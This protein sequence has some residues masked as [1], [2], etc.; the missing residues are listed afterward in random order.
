MKP[1][2]PP[3]YFLAAILAMV[4]LHLLFPVR[5]LVDYPWRLAGLL[6]LL[7]GIA[8]ALLADQSFKRHATT[9]KPFERSSALVTN[10]VF[11]FSRNPMYLSMILILVGVA[12]LLGTLSP[13]LIVP[14]L[15]VILDRLFIAREEQMLGETFGAAYAEYRKRVRRWV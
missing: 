7:A 4:G 14:V 1:I 9:I 3:V 12:L 5:H 10:G 15:A 8:V 6:P 2:Y 13:W 11:R